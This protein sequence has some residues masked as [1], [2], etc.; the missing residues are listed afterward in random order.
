MTCPPLTV[1][2][3]GAGGW[4][5]LSTSAQHALRSAEV[6]V[7]SRR[8]LDLLEPF[9]AATR[10]LLPTPLLPALDELVQRLAARRV[11]ILASGDP[12]F[13]GIG[14]TLVRLLGAQRL[15]VLPHPSSVSLAA[16]RLGWALDDVEV[17]S[18]VG[19]P[20][21]AAAVAL[22][23]GRRILLLTAT[24]TS[25]AEVREL[26]TQQ[27]YGASPVTVLA[28]LAGPDEHIDP[29]P[30]AE[31]DALAVIAVECV[32][33]R[34]AT[35]RSRFAAL[36][37]EAYEN[38]GQLT[39]QE[40]RAF[41]L[42][43]L[44]PLP[45]QLLWDVGAGSGSIGIEWMR[46]HPRSMTVAVEPREDRRARIARNAEQLGVPGLQIISGSAP[47]ALAQLPAPDAIFVG[48]GVSVAGVLEACVDALGPGGRLVADAVT[49]ESENV[50]A[51][52]YGRLGG[53]LTRLSVQRASPV[54]SFTAWRPAMPV[55]Q[56]SWSRT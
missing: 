50:L 36:T 17:V 3:I 51:G 2:G 40:I 49:L 12:M 29:D 52:W 6:V 11:V 5:E 35:P 46:T 23:P 47:G 31:H 30:P 1:V 42:A 9:I 33:D 45:G 43:A 39:K 15:H 10:E 34:G 21:T 32:A 56:W 37:D 7:G 13:Y 26:L 8:Q 22:S 14:T 41:A 24:R 54:G 27:G 38:D 16:A 53:R 19:R 55:T 48:G 4:S 25:A 18:A 20:L 44:V 28:Q